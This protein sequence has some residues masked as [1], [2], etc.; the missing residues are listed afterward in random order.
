[1]REHF[2]EGVGQWPTERPAPARPR[3]KRKLSGG[4][5]MKR[6][7]SLQSLPYGFSWLIFV[8]TNEDLAID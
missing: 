7:V 1:M 2:L 3:R 6:D 8:P 5:S 4:A